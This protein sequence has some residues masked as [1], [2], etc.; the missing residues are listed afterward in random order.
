MGTGWSRQQAS[1]SLAWLRQLASNSESESALC[2]EVVLARPSAPVSALQPAM[3]LELG[4][5]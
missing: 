5:L 1:S 2:L 4:C 3:I